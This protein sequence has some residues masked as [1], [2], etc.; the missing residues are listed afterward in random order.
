MQLRIDNAS[1]SSVEYRPDSRLV[2][3]VNRVE[4]LAH[5]NVDP[6]GQSTPA[7]RG[8]ERRRPVGPAGATTG[9]LPARPRYHRSPGTQ[10]G[11]AGGG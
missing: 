3:A 7:T 10:P 11:K 8:A 1:I 5:L 4:H 6:A 9:G 2:L